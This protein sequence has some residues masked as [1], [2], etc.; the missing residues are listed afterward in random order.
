MGLTSWAKTMC[1]KVVLILM[2]ILHRQ[3]RYV[4]ENPVASIAL[5]LVPKTNMFCR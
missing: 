5:R 2:V 3:A 1:I 4:I